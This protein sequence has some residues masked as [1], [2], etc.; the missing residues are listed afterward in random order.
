M[1]FDSPKSKFNRSHSAP[2]FHRYPS[3]P[4]HTSVIDLIGKLFQEF[5]VSCQDGIENIQNATLTTFMPK[6]LRHLTSIVRNYSKDVFVH[7][8]GD[9]MASHYSSCVFEGINICLT[10]ELQPNG[11]RTVTRKNDLENVLLYGLLGQVSLK[12][13][14]VDDRIKGGKYFTAPYGSDKVTDDDTSD[15]AGTSAIVNSS[16][17]NFI[18]TGTSSDDNNDDNATTNSNN[19]KVSVHSGFV[20]VT[21]KHLLT[22][23]HR[24]SIPANCFFTQKAD[25]DC[26]FLCISKSRQYH[27]HQTFLWTSATSQP[28]SISRK[29]PPSEVGDL[30]QCV[31]FH[32]SLLQHHSE[33]DMIHVRDA[34]KDALV[35]RCEALDKTIR[36]RGSCVSTNINANVNITD[37]SINANV[38]ADVNGVVSRDIFRNGGVGSGVVV[39]LGGDVRGIDSSFGV[40]VFPGVT[41]VSRLQPQDMEAVVGIGRA[42]SLFIVAGGRLDS[43]SSHL[44][45]VVCNND[46]VVIFRYTVFSSDMVEIR[47]HLFPDAAETYIHNHRSNLISMSLYGD[48]KHISWSVLP[49]G[50]HTE[51]VRA[52]SGVMSEAVCCVGD[53]VESSSFQHCK[54]QTYFLDTGTYHTVTCPTTLSIASSSTSTSSTT[55]A[56]SSSLSPME[57]GID[58]NINIPHKY[59]PAD[60][61]TGTELTLFVKDKLSSTI[62]TKILNESNGEDFRSS[63]TVLSRTKTAELLSVIAKLLVN[64]DGCNQ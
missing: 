16:T 52:S 29:P 50:S 64:A 54:G 55:A 4:Q 63:E 51:K 48:Y 18:N 23:Q 61:I 12:L 11:T 57:S 7:F 53:V 35:Y 49:T 34:F 60:N 21:Q 62:V 27:L 14:A 36:D 19:R 41:P 13:V 46:M 26:V 1:D 5:D 40:G 45:E 42:L 44:A 8:D 59:D 17:I 32:L 6:F 38:G 37:V 58:I 9:H 20:R 24:T 28:T 15:I 25:S 33:S 3:Q 47:L 22:P 2:S 30:Q 43:S 39:G 10:L 56:A 31:S